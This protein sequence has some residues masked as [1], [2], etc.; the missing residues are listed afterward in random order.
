VDFSQLVIWE[1]QLQ[2]ISRLHT[3]SD[4]GGHFDSTLEKQQQCA[5][6]S[7]PLVILPPL[8]ITVTSSS[9]RRFPR[10]FGVGWFLKR[11][12]NPSPIGRHCWTLKAASICS[13]TIG[14]RFVRQLALQTSATHSPIGLNSPS[15]P[16]SKKRLHLYDL[17][18]LFS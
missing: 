18:C 11:L 5:C 6:V 17:E 15:P 7:E 1:T 2:S 8:N 12:H 10:R 14:H 4:F 16:L 9:L 3:S 13:L